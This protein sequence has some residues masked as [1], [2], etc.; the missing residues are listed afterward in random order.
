MEN[1]LPQLETLS[2]A[3]TSLGWLEVKAMVSRHGPGHQ[4]KGG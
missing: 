2:L 3:P 4:G 1:S